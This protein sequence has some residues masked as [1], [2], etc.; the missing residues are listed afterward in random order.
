MRE[1]KFRA[2]DKEMKIL[3][4][5]DFSLHSSSLVATPD[6]FIVMQYTGRKDMHG[7]EIYD[8]DVL[9]GKQKMLGDNR[10]GRD[11]KL[12]SWNERK[13]G[14]SVMSAEHREIIGNIYENPE[15]AKRYE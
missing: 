2:W 8:G 5:F 15:L 10:N 1:I 3:G 4:Y 12:A 6:R 13:N 14:W 7:K 11:Y 9:R